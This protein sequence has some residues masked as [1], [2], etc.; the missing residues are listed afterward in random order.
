MKACVDNLCLKGH[1]AIEAPCTK[2]L[3]AL[4]HPWVDIYCETGR[5]AI[6]IHCTIDPLRFTGRRKKQ[7]KHA[8]EVT[9]TFKCSPSLTQPIQACRTIWCS[10]TQMWLSTFEL[11]CTSARGCIGWGTLITVYLCMVFF[12]VQCVL[13]EK[14]LAH[15]AT[16]MHSKR[17]IVSRPKGTKIRTPDR[18]DY[19]LCGCIAVSSE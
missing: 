8:N 7:S 15:T 1:R 19:I 14:S 9:I 5:R 11:A 2:T 3:L 6:K 17:D 10:N 12:S 18:L 16:R 13:L 4:R